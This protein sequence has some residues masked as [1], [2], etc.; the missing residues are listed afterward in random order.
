[1]SP[2]SSRWFGPADLCGAT[3]LLGGV[4]GV[5]LVGQDQAT[6]PVLV[7]SERIWDRAEH[8]AFTG[9]CVAGDSLWCTF[10]ESDRHVHGLDGSIRVIRS[11]DRMN[12][13]S[14]ALLD[15]PG[16]DL[17]DPKITVMPDGRLM[18]LIGGSR[19]VDHDLREQA[20]RVAFGDAGDGTFGVLQP[21]HLPAECATGKDWLWRLTWHDGVGY[22]AI[23]HA[24]QRVQSLDLVTTRDGITC[25]ALARVDVPLASPRV[26]ATETTL[27]FLEDGTMLALVRCDG[28]S[29]VGMLGRALPPYRDFTWVALDRRLGGPDLIVLDGDRLLAGSRVFPPPQSGPGRDDRSPWTEL[30]WID[31]KG[32]TRTLCRLP[33]GGDCSYPGFAL[34][35]DLLRVSYYTS[36]REPTSIHL[37]TLR[38]K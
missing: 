8:N 19:Y 36:H 24:S 28:E 29:A 27:R 3:V 16:I 2:R 38:L 1:M 11:P 10:R 18:L 5:P 15:E 14:A 7:H 13:R 35:G 34:D 33:S 31:T 26:R 30:F 37:A 21:M 20:P 4:L 32:A 17:R 12:W 6:D 23:Y 25:T 22:G 9:L